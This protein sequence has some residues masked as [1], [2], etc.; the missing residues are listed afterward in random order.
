MSEWVND[1]GTGLT[2]LPLTLPPSIEYRHKGLLNSQ[3]VEYTFVQGLD[4]I[5]CTSLCILTFVLNPPQPKF[6]T[7]MKKVLFGSL[8]AIALSSS[9]VPAYADDLVHVQRLLSTGACEDCNLSRAGLIYADLSNANLRG[10]NLRG[11]NLSQTDLTNADL[12]NAN[13]VGAVLFDANLEGANLQ[14]SD[15]RGADLRGAFLGDANLEGALLEGASLMGAYGL[16]DT[17]ETPGVL[18]QWGILEAENA[19]YEMA[20][21]YYSR[22]LQADPDNPE[23]YLARSIALFRWGDPEGAYADAKQAEQLFMEQDNAEGQQNALMLAEGIVEVQRRIVEGPEPPPPDFLGLIGS[24][25]TLLIQF[26]AR[27]ALPF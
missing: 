15:L 17:I 26:A 18:F 19:N 9:I 1:V 6:A 25:S 11:A 13:L 20:I 7:V 10:A 14:G 8:A 4:N 12:S 2:S 27:G 16:P 22:S 3:N 23:V 5:A 21:R 24:L